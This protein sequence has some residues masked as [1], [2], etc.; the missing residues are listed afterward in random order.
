MSETLE[1]TQK[2][3]EQLGVTRPEQVLQLF[4]G[5]RAFFDASA[6]A[7]ASTKD[8]ARLLELHSAW[9]NEVS[10]VIQRI[11]ENWVTSAPL[12]LR[13]TSERAA[14]HFRVH[15]GVGVRAV[16]TLQQMGIHDASEVVGLFRLLRDSFD[17]DIQMDVDETDV[18]ITRVN[19]LGRKT[20]I[21]TW[22]RDHWLKSPPAELRREVG[23][24]FN[25][26]KAHVAH[27]YQRDEY[28]PAIQQTY[29]QS[30][31]NALVD[32]QGEQPILPPETTAI[33]VDLSL[34]G[35]I[36]PIGSRHLIRQ[37]LQEL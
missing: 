12:N 20:G 24:C 23:R 17:Q 10:G 14:K 1:K 27:V 26:L 13:G 34:P 4:S 7:A 5:L 18:E 36:H 29:A 19:W 25:E 9:S 3:F 31:G 11:H 35:V 33:P 32:V 15:V 16:Q 37:V 22:A 21:L 6:L 30:S 2:T 28:R 8:S